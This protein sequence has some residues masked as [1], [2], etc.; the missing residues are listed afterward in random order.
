MLTENRRPRDSFTHVLKR[1]A[2]RIDNK[3]VY[4]IK[5]HN[6]I[7]HQ[8][9]VSRLRVETLWVVGSYARGALDCGD[10]DL[11]AEI[12]YEGGF[13]PARSLV[14]RTILGNPKDVRLYLGTPDKNSA[15]VAFPE[16]RVVWSAKNPD[17]NNAIDAILP[18]PD[19]I[20]YPRRYDLLPVR[21]EQI[22]NCPLR[23]LDEIVDLYEKGIITWEWIPKEEIHMR[24][25]DWSDEAVKF[26][27]RLHHFSGK[28]SQEA[29]QFVIEILDSFNKGGRWQSHLSERSRFRYE[30][31]E[32]FVGRP[33]LNLD[34]LDSFSCSQLLV[35][36]H[37]SRRGPNGIWIIKRGNNH[38]IEQA[39]NGRG[40]YYLTSK[41]S[42]WSIHEMAGHRNI[43]T[44]DLF[45]SRMAATR[46]AEEEMK[47][48]EMDSEIIDLEV[49]YASGTDLLRIISCH[50]V[51]DIDSVR[52]IISS[53]GIWY[54]KM[55]PG[56]EIKLA[57]I[58]DIS[59]ALTS[60]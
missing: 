16:A 42:P 25:E 3:S 13:A 7:L 47:D 20:R 22:P 4:E 58:E 54:E 44:L 19:A 50:D 43:R 46:H 6:D 23:L 55:F 33:V 26:F 39:F 18:D 2:E 45:T 35:A 48:A 38:P 17:W 12:M 51:I 52:H 24:M 15:E 34:L 14:S 40:A 8:D 36:P 21:H 11:V 56:G 10:L 60:E 59:S 27:K 1:I 41:Q 28:K 5:W 37:I 29:M 31:T 49:A 30:G 57:S 53:D 9:E 32:I